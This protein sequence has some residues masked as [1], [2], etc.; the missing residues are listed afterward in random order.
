MSPDEYEMLLITAGL[1]SNGRYGF[2]MKPKSWLEFLACHRFVA[3]DCLIDLVM[4]Q[5]DINAYI[6][7]TTPSQTN[8]PRFYAIRIGY[9]TG[10]SADKIENQRGRDGRLLTAPPRLNGLGMK[11]QSFRIDVSALIWD[12]TVEN[13]DDTTDEDIDDNDSN[14]DNSSNEESKRNVIDE[15]DA[16]SPTTKKLHQQRSHQQRSLMAWMSYIQICHV[17]LE[18]R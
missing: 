5:M 1:A 10:Q 6:N 16:C 14:E 15:D 17:H 8:R 18:R 12:Y 4:K 13:D 9:K 3:N 2:R 7:G 11:C